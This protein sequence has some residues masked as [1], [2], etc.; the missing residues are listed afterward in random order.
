M[1]RNHL[2]DWAFLWILSWVSGE[3]S[4]QGDLKDSVNKMMARRLNPS[5]RST[6]P[7][8]LGERTHASPMMGQA[9]GSSRGHMGVH[10]PLLHQSTS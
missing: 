2:L 10:R 9:E 8:S 5:R 1:S 3:I 7:L 4:K 6:W